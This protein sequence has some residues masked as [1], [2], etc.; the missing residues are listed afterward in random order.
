MAN[1]RTVDSAAWPFVLNDLQ[2]LGGTPGE[3]LRIAEM[4]DC[5]LHDVAFSLVE[6]TLQR[7]RDDAC[8]VAQQ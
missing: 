5:G 2:R 7:L 4:V 3:V 1:R 6:A 8:T